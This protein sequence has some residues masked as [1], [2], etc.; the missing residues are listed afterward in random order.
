[1]EEIGAKV[2]P[3]ALEPLGPATLPAAGVLA[4]RNHF[5]HV[6]VDPA[7]LVTPEGDQSP[8]EENGTVLGVSLDDALAAL[9]D[10]DLPDAK[11]EIGLRRFAELR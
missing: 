9:R 8:L 11:T 6:V 5:F 10:G 1:M 7:L 2:T 4:E 3:S